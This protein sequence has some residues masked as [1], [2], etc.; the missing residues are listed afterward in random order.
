MCKLFSE[1]EGIWRRWRLRRPAISSRYRI[2]VGWVS[3]CT[4]SQEI[5]SLPVQSV[6]IMLKGA[7]H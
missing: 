7:G 6:S 1:E 4:P 2:D 3:A 5:G